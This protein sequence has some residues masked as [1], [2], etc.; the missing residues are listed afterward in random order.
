MHLN[1]LIRNSLNLFQQTVWA[2]LLQGVISKVADTV[3]DVLFMLSSCN[4]GLHMLHL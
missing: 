4:S 2:C 1:T 3:A